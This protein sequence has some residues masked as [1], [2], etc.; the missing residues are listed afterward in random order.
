M[1]VPPVV[2]AKGLS[3][4]LGNVQAL[5][6][7]SVEFRAGEIHAVVGENGAGKTTLMN[8]LSGFLRPDAGTISVAGELLELGRPTV[9]RSRGLSMVHQHFMLVP[10]FSVEENFAL[11]RMERLGGLLDVSALSKRAVEIAQEF[12]WRLDL[13]ATTRQLSVGA[14]QRVEILKA[15]SQGGKILI[16]DEPTAVLSSEEVDELFGVLG[17][18]KRRG[19]AIVLIAHKL[20]EVLKVADRLTVLRRGKVVASTT[21]ENITGDEIAEWMVG[22]IAITSTHQRSISDQP[23][24][25]VHGLKVM[26]DRGEDSVRDVTFEICRGEVVG[27]GGVDGNGQIELA[28][29]LARVRSVRS[30]MIEWPANGPAEPRVAFIPADRQSDGLALEM[31]VLDNLLIGGL[32]VP[33]LWAGPLMRLRQLKEW[34]RSLVARFRI[35]IGGLGQPVAT[36]SGGNQQKIVVSRSLSVTPDLLVAVNP[37]RGLDFQATDFVQSQIDLAAANGA[38]VALFSTDQDELASL[39]DRVFFM[40]RGQ[41]AEAEGSISF[42]GG[43]S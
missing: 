16:L 38:A 4:R 42:L 39:A 20:S 17:E 10:Q 26:G 25:I 23:A 41:I 22:D 19:Q 7:V 36:L 2:E 30:G 3:I 11:A 18:L 13:K 35:K 5:S 37:T 34:A 6:D 14:Q 27:F 1:E 8:I 15:L 12:G 31:S 32:E 21:M 29:A 40:S 33:S 28:E 24:V 9:M 43:S